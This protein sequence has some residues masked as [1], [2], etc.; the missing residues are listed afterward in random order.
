MSGVV[1]RI[2]ILVVFTLHG[3]SSVATNKNAKVPK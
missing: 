2:V 3:T 1:N